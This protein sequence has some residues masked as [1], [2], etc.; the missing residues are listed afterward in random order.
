M[1]TKY[2]VGSFGVGT[3]IV[4]GGEEL[5]GGGRLQALCSLTV[6]N[7][8]K[9]HMHYVKPWLADG[10]TTTVHKVLTVWSH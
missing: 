3:V 6:I 7:K 10:Y 5:G 1:N 9:Q 4:S 8:T 2:G